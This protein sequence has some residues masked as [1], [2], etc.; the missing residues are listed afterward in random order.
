MVSCY[1]YYRGQELN[2]PYQLSP[3]MLEWS[4]HYTKAPFGGASQHM[5]SLLGLFVGV[6]RTQLFLCLRKPIE[7][8]F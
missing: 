7:F 6:Y 2:S 3:Y 8:V 4:A 5:P 1:H